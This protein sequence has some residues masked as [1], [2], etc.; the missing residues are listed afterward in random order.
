MII[1]RCSYCFCYPRIAYYSSYVNHIIADEPDD[2]PVPIFCG[3]NCMLAW[4][5]IKKN[6]TI[7]DVIRDFKI[8]SNI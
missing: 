1:S 8:F 4:A 2:S 6:M 3:E 7:E 5:V